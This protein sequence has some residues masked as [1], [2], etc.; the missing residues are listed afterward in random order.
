MASVQAKLF[1][2]EL[3]KRVADQCLQCFGGY[4]FMG[5]VPPRALLPRRAG[6]HHRRRH[7]GDHARNH[8]PLACGRGFRGRGTTE[9]RGASPRTPVRLHSPRWQPPGHRRSPRS[10]LHLPAHLPGDP[11]SRPSPGPFPAVSG[12]S[13]RTAGGP[14]S[15]ISS[16]DLPSRSGPWPSKT[17]VAPWRRDSAARPPAS[18]R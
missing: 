10:R 2:T 1:A 11:P 13:A 18:W 8:R 12:G 6:R 5:G 15:T 3:G 7:I 4:G 14:S 17:G 16:R 9:E